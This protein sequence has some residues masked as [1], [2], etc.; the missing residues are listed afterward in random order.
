M[1]KQR[2]SRPKLQKW[3]KQAKDAEMEIAKATIDVFALK[4]IQIFLWQSCVKII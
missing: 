3:R 1:K 2:K 4:C